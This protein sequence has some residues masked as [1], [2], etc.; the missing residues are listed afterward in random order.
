MSLYVSMLREFN[1]KDWLRHTKL[2]GSVIG[3][4]ATLEIHHFF[5]RALL[6]KKGYATDLINTFANYVIISKDSNLNILD[7]EP[8]A[9]LKEEKVK[10]EELYKQCVPEDK[11]LW[12]SKNYKKFL[13]E[14]RKLLAERANNIFY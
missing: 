1:A 10:N 2:D 14:R 13:V 7:K 4:N 6:I 3:H 11:E 12:K 5:P 8:H 9:Y